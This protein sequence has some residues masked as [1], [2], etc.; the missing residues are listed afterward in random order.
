[1]GANT[2][3]VIEGSNQNCVKRHN[4]SIQKLLVSTKQIRKNHPGGQQHLKN[5]S[6]IWNM[7]TVEHKN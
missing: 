7:N 1:M 4:M 3:N 2:I 6:K 5:I